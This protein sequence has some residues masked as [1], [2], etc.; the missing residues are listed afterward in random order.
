MLAP[1]EPTGQPL[2]TW[3][4]LPSAGN[5]APT[6]STEEDTSSGSVSPRR[7][8]LLSE[9]SAD[10]LTNLACR[11]YLLPVCRLHLLIPCTFPSTSWCSCCP[12]RWPFVSG[13]SGSYCQDTPTHS[14]CHLVSLPSSVLRRP[15]SD[16]DGG[17]GAERLGDFRVAVDAWISSIPFSHRFPR[18][19]LQQ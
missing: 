6:L 12:R 19:T 3:Q 7:T 14:H 11:V 9:Q 1:Q 17:D 4:P 16:S 8:R 15:S 5:H 2:L 13:R 18:Y 10:P